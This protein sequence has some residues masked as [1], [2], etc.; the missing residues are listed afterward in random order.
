MV[1]P[2]WLHQEALSSGKAD[3]VDL[4]GA[5]SHRRAVAAADAVRSCSIRLRCSLG[6]ASDAGSEN[7]REIAAL[8][9]LGGKFTP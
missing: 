1:D 5:A 7:E 2:R 6:S 4:S 3:G 9:A 8:G